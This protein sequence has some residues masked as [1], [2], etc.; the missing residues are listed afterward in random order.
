MSAT[1]P[2]REIAASP[3]VPARWR[4][5]R[6]STWLWWTCLSGL[7]LWMFADVLFAANNFVYR[8]AAH[9]YY[10]LFKHIA[11]QWG[12][13]RVPLWN[14]YENLGTPLVAQGTSSVFY[15]GKLLFALPIGFDASFKLYVVGH[16]FL[17]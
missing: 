14:P 8:D 11:A 16:V 5:S 9:F 1:L 10:P 7:L 4:E 3:T 13:G 17:A 6:P 12:A 15:P 2:T